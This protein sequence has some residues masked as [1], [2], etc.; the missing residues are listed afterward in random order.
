MPQP[1][2]KNL[3][4]RSFLKGRFDAAP[5]PEKIRPPWTS[6]ETVLKECTNCGDCI[7]A[8]PENI[9]IFDENDLPH[10]SFDIAGCTFCGA[11]AEACN[12]AVYT[13]ARNEPWP[14]KIQI[15]DACLIKSGVT[16]Q[17]CTDQCEASA[18]TFN[19]RARPNGVVQIDLSSCTGCGTCISS[20]PA[21]AL[22]IHQP[23]E[24]RG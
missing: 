12:V 19:I 21:S 7:S 11:C 3:S 20:C 24:E 1:L 22:S 18:L 4:R 13:S 8:C 5:T 16:C 14:S 15:S 2:Q 23:R 10:V 6:E 17:L 9:L